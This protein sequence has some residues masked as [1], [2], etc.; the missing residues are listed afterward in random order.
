MMCL[1][2]CPTLSKVSTSSQDGVNSSSRISNK[3]S[4]TKVVILGISN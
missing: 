4:N 2:P 1:A 3:S